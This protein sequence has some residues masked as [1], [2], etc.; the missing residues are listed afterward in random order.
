RQFISG[1]TGSAGV[2]VVTSDSAALSTDGRYIIQ[3]TKQLDS[4]WTLLNSALPDVPTWQDWSA[5]KSA[6]GKNVAVDASL[7]ASS[8]AKKL[9]EK[10]HKCGGA[11]LIPMEENLVDIVWGDNRP[12][13]PRETVTNLSDTFS[14][15]SV[16][17]KLQDL[18][19]ELEKRNSIGFVI[20]MLDEIAWLFNL[21]GSDVP[22][23]PVFFSY[24]IVTLESVTLYI[25]ETKLDGAAKA[26]LAQNNIRIR[27][28]SSI[29]DDALQLQATASR[30][31]QGGNG[32]DNRLLISNKGSWVL[33]R[34]LG[35]DDMVDEIR[36]PIGDAKAIKN[37]VELEGMRACHVRD[38][39]ALIEYFAWL[40]DQL[41][42]KKAVLD[43]VQGDDKLTQLR[44]KHHNFVC[45]SFPT[46]SSSGPNAAVI[47]YKPV[48][49][50]CSV[51]DPA[52]IYL[53]DSGAQFLDGTTDVTRTLHYGKPTDQEREA[54][55]LVL[56][57]N[58]ALEL[59]VFPKGTTGYALD[60]LARQYL[61]KNGLDYR[62]GTGH[63]VGSYLN[64]HE[65]PI[66]IGTRAQHAEVAL[67]PGNVISNEPGYYVEN[68]FGI[69]IENI[70]L[71]NRRET[72][73]AFGDQPFLGFE[74][75]TMVPYC[76]NLIDINL[77]TN[78][79]KKWINSYH[80][81]VLERTKNYFLDDPL[82]LSWLQ[83]E[84]QPLE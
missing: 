6:G 12:S 80:A 81:Q 42:A 41:I 22:Y 74:N 5:E 79:E 76:R 50:N 67:S 68:G 63:G 33:Q 59:A 73:Y 32:A 62:H 19:R 40:E 4:N 78:D 64:V 13:R 45:L 1:F 84:T 14:G 52:Q 69:R 27:P 7:I 48:R 23:N 2:A 82:T 60:C 65:G 75:V 11:D 25:D 66:G 44:S 56:K 70:I 43:E 46:I 36:S 51:I 24:A 72:K 55:T 61:W 31:R 10:I 38:G 37:E 35:G 3:A 21:R 77:L 17:R 34:A 29:L 71:V 54:Y 39:A 15:K 47:H 49:G 9:L 30:L 20:S 16:Y 18:R 83:R 53:C 28:Y 57:G 26:H 58:I 8:T